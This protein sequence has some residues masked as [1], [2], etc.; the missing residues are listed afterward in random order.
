MDYKSGGY[1]QNPAIMGADGQHIVG[2]DEY[3]VF[4]NKADIALIL[5]APDL[6]AALMA[7]LGVK[8]CGHGFAC[9]CADDMAIAALKKA[10]GE[11]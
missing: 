11:A 10:R 1:S 8:A 6:Y 2:C 4:E 9:I 5:A 3:D 7:Y